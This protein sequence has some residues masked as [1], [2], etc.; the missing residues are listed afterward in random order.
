MVPPFF[1]FMDKL[2]LLRQK[3]WLIRRNIKDN[4]FRFVFFIVDKQMKRK[5]YL[6]SVKG[7]NSTFYLP[8]IKNDLIQQRIFW[9][10]NYF[11]RNELEIVCRHF[12]NG[13]IG[14]IVKNSNVLDIGSNIGNHTLYFL[15]ECGAKHVYCFEPV[16]D[17]FHILQEN[18]R[19]N[20]LES[21]TTLMNVGVGSKRCSARVSSYTKNNTGMTTLNLSKDGNI[22]I[23]SIDELKSLQK[24]G[25]IKI[26]VEG[27]EEEVVKG[28]LNTLRK[29]RPYIFIEIQNEHFDKI[30]SLLKENG[31]QYIILDEQWHYKNYLFFCSIK[32]WAKT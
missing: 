19:I 31:Y 27:F 32:E 16:R 29:D 26:D 22:Q 1:I 13:E 7:I 10:K 2:L 9:N 15:N 4:F 5:N 6:F 17:T 23:V 24:I 20:H 3:A 25:L 11:E 18:I 12:H 28:M 8:Y 21:R 30:N 14:R